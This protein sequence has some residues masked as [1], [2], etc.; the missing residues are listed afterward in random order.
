MCRTTSAGSGVQCA[1]SITR[2]SKGGSVRSRQRCVGVVSDFLKRTHEKLDYEVERAS[3]CDE[4]RGNS[5]FSFVMSD[6]GERRT[7]PCRSCE[8]TPTK[9]H[10]KLWKTPINPAENAYTY[11]AKTPS[12]DPW[13]HH[14]HVRVQRPSWVEQTPRHELVY[15]S[16]CA[17]HAAAPSEQFC[18]M[19]F[20]TP[21]E[22]YQGL[23]APRIA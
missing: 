16:G 8:R 1:R 19:R 23:A 21:S 4:L 11:G 13:F 2:R 9:K 22:K 17:H 18:K 12:S 10:G 15:L 7:V 5:R 6:A 14:L 3:A 20:P